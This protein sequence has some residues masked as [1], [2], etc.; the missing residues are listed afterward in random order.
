ME[1]EAIRVRFSTPE[2]DFGKVVGRALGAG[3]DVKLDRCE[4][5]SAP[6]WQE[7]YDCVLLDL[8]EL[9]GSPAPSR[10]SV[11]STSFEHRRLRFPS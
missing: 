5:I 11:F 4:D 8:R 6:G 3:F 2:P 1:K 7:S 9:P 10:S